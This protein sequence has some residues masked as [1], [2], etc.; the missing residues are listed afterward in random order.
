L[1]VILLVAIIGYS[2]SGYYC[3][4]YWWLLLLIL[5]VA[6]VGYSIGAYCWLFYWCLFY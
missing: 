5:L 3:L 2:T 1:L 4:F 6:I